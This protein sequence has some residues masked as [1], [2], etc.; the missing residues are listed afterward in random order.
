MKKQIIT[1]EL[2]KE[3]SKVKV[4]EIMNI[5]KEEGVEEIAIEFKDENKD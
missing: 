1:F 2:D 4:D 3:L 5:L